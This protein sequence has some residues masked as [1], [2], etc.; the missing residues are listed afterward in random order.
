MRA[1]KT[2]I[3]PTRRGGGG[4]QDDGV[5]HTAVL[6]RGNPGSFTLFDVARVTVVVVAAAA[7]RR[8]RPVSLRY[9]PTTTKAVA[10][11]PDLFH[12]HRRRRRR[13]RRPVDAVPTYAHSTQR[14]AHV[15]SG[16]KC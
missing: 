15:N 12:R 14:G 2:T 10:T 4:R 16:G 8:R 7:P 11:T 3:M 6:S 9:T 13:R 1:T 5:V